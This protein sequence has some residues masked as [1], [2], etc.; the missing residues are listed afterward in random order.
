[1][2]N[3]QPMRTFKVYFH[4]NRRLSRAEF[5]LFV[6][7]Y[8]TAEEAMAALNGATTLRGLRLFGWPAPGSPNVRLIDGT[9]YQP[10]EAEDVMEIAATDPI[11]AFRAS[12]PQPAEG[13]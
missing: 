6:L 1:M 11:C 13:V 8:R 5:E 9:K 12:A 4:P 3:Q 2:H 7:P 10:F